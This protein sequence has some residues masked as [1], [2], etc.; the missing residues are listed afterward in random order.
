MG[1]IRTG[2]GHEWRSWVLALERSMCY[3]HLGVREMAF[4][5]KGTVTTS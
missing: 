1:W 4:R 3:H 2:L 5:L